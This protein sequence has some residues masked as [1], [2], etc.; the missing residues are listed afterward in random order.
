MTKWQES[1]ITALAS[2]PMAWE[3]KKQKVIMAIYKSYM[4]I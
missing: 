4:A 1:C 3:A 2:S